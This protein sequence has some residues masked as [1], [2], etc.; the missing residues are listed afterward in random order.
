MA[1]EDTIVFPSPQKVEASRLAD[2]HFIVN[3]HFFSIATVISVAIPE[4]C[5]VKQK[6]NNDS[7]YRLH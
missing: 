1:D 6:T 7:N 3:I 2:P 5:L 4:E